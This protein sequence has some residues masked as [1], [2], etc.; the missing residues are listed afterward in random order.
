MLVVEGAT[1]AG[2][3][4]LVIDGH[5]VGRREVAMGV[6]RDDT[7]FPAVQALLADAE[8]EAAALRAIVC[9]AGPGSF[10][11]L[12]IAGSLAKGLAFAGACE[13]YAV[14][15]LMLAAATVRREGRYV[16]HSDALRGERFAL[17]VSI[18]ADG[19]AR[20]E[21]AV[22]RVAFADLV[23]IGRDRTRLAVLSSPAA[24]LE[25]QIVLPDA[26]AIVRC[27]DW[28]AEG[29]VSL[30]R[31]EPDYGRLAEAQVKWEEAHG[32]ALADG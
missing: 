12:R 29:A 16:V 9:G 5:V 14:S 10:T 6:T 18:D 2:S 1:S 13:L 21:G 28:F 22:R 3:T 7:L 17:D 27:V 4:A 25:S 30:D 24:E 15:S 23:Q 32:R 8:L 31:W 20:A 11:S 26:A 19:F